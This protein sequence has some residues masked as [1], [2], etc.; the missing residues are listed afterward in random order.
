MKRGASNHNFLIS[1]DKPSG[2]TS[3]DVVNQLRREYGEG[4]IG[5]MGTLDP[6]ASGM[7]IVG[8]GSAARLN[9]FIEGHDKTYVVTASF[10]RA[11]NTYDAD[12]EITE[13][14]EVSSSFDPDFSM[15]LGAQTQVPPAFSAVKINGQPAYKSA[16]KGKNVE[17]PSRN[18]EVYS[19]KLVARHGNDFDIELHVSKGTYIRSL[20]HDFG[21]RIGVPAYVKALRRI[22]IGDIYEFKK[23]DAAK[24]L[25]F[26]E[27]E[28]NDEMLKLIENGNKLKLFDS[29]EKP[30]SSTGLTSIIYKGKLRAIYDGEKAVCVFHE[31]IDL[32]R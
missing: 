8:V 31:G 2:V 21:Q 15:L 11:T 3:H 17:L 10:G 27:V 28:S 14:C 7:L 6:L 13:E 4:R 32:C 23:L 18:I 9:R 29:E 24:V 26:D 12:G 1:V 25:G 30:T 22:K 16:R 20:V 5:H 19:S